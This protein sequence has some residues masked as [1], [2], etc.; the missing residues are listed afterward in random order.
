[1]E[2]GT[3]Q[4]LFYVNIPVLSQLATVKLSPDQPGQFRIRYE[5][6]P[7]SLSTVEAVVQSLRII[8]PQTPRLGDLLNCF[9]QMVDRQLSHPNA[10]YD[11]LPL[12]L[13]NSSTL[14]TP[15]ALRDSLNDVVVACG[16]KD[17]HSARRSP[18]KRRANLSY[19][20]Q[21]G[22]VMAAPFPPFSSHQNSCP[23]GNCGTLIYSESM[24]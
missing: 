22:L 24:E 7:I 21:N 17:P 6:T 19:G 15:F 11:G 18:H 9:H 8:E 13:R 1:M 2:P 20:T 16:E 23:I 5:P 4:K 12:H 14:N 10:V 3:S